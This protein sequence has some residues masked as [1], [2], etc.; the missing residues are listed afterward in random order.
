[1]LSASLARSLF[2]VRSRGEN[3]AYLVR[4]APARC[5]EERVCARPSIDTLYY[6]SERGARAR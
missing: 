3:C 5:G 6:N 4:D 1:M 2:F